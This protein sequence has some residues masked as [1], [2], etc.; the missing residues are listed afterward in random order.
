[1]ADLN[2][3]T[4]KALSASQIHKLQ[5]FSSPVTTQYHDSRRKILIWKYICGNLIIFHNIILLSIPWHHDQLSIHILS[6]SLSHCPPSPPLSPWLRSPWLGGYPSIPALSPTSSQHPQPLAPN[7]ICCIKS[8][9]AHWLI[10][11][12]MFGSFGTLKCLWQTGFPCGTCGTQY[13]ASTWPTSRSSEKNK[14]GTC[15]SE[16]L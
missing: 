15:V 11:M 14:Q 7:G 10:A 1:M 16:D 6:C 12:T 9:Y 2:M 8:D 13:G 3:N 5:R 4:V